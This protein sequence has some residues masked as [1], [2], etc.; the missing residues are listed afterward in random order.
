MDLSVDRAACA[1]LLGSGGKLRS[2]YLAALDFGVGMH[3]FVHEAGK[4]GLDL[5]FA[6]RPL[7]AVFTP[8]QLEAMDFD[9]NGVEVVG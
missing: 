8:D 1:A 3:V 6:T 2:V 7:R 9:G 4:R 5:R